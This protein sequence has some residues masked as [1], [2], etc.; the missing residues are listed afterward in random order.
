MSKH[1]DLQKAEAALKQ[2]AK[3]AVSDTRLA[4]SGRLLVKAKARR[5]AVAPT[6]PKRK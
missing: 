3:T 5:A 6:P 4:R 1:F 2:A